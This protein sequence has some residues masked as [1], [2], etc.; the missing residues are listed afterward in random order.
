M[1]KQVEWPALSLRKHLTIT[2]AH[3]PKSADGGYG[4]TL[5]IQFW[6]VLLQIIHSDLV[7]MAN[8]DGTAVFP[9]ALDQ[10]F[11]LAVYKLFGLLM[12]ENTSRVM[13]GIR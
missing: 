8:A 2:V 10:Q 9:G 12:V 4:D 1:R 3:G 6:Q 5:L 11:K 7:R 13:V